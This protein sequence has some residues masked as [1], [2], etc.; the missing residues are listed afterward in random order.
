MKQSKHPISQSRRRFLRD[1][2]I[3]GGAAAVAAS[4]PGIALAD[5][6][7]E[8]AAEPSTEGYRLTAHI[9]AYYKSAAS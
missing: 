9:L 8:R 3:T 4:A 1:A 5:T 6:T 7:A 2:G